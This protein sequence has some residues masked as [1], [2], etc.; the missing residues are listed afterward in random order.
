MKTK[1]L[2]TLSIVGA[3][4]AP[5]IPAAAAA[6]QAPVAGKI[7]S[8]VKKAGCGTL[9]AVVKGKTLKLTVTKKTVCG[10]QKGESGGP[11]SSCAALS[12]YKGWK[13]NLRY[14]G[15]VCTFVSVVYPGPKKK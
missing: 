8:F 3:L 5:A 1:T 13:A 11:L 2:A 15:H 9:T 10:Y 12:K 6:G 7:V 4:A 14:T